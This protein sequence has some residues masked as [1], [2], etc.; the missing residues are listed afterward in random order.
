MILA[1]PRTSDRAR[2]RRRPPSL[3][4]PPPASACS[5]IVSVQV[6]LTAGCRSEAPGPGAL[7]TADPHAAASPQRIDT[8]ERF[9]LADGSRRCARTRR[10]KAQA[11]QAARTRRGVRPRAPPAHARADASTS[12]DR[13]GERDHDADRPLAHRACSVSAY[14]LTPSGRRRG[15]PYLSASDL[16]AAA[17][18]L[19]A[20]RCEPGRG[21]DERRAMAL[22]DERASSSTVRGG[23]E[24]V[25]LR[26]VLVV[27]TG[28]RPPARPL[29]SRSGLPGRP[30]PR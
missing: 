20:R 16:R 19:P 27:S 24:E 4:R 15:Q 12:N 29:R 10:R 9:N 26:R 11:R 21:H 30:A 18:L 22:A 13:V 17:E 14:A 25:P 23:R 8:W 2:G 5:Q 3:P 7:A 1:R 28:R 6:P